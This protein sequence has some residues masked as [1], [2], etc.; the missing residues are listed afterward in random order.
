MK[1]TNYSISSDRHCESPDETFFKGQCL[2][3]STTSRSEHCPENMGLYDNENNEGICDCLELTGEQA[4][5]QL[6]P[7]YSDETGVC[8][9]Q[10]TQVWKF[11]GNFRVYNYSVYLTIKG[12]CE[13]GQW[14]VL[15]NTSQCE[16]VPEGCPTDGLHVSW[17]SDPSMA[18][19]CW[20]IWTQGPCEKG[21][22]LHLAQD[23]E[24][25][26]VYCSYQLAEYSSSN[27]QSY[28]PPC[29][30]G[31]YRNLYGRCTKPGV[32]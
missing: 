24:E 9:R 11:K 6:R 22:L 16:P 3:V 27:S 10:N 20:K 25:I 17:S 26:L 21:Q 1:I 32:G 31:T 4:K 28:Y 30:A 18:K 7:I 12:P 13:N 8:H 19:Q 23:S 14:F 2:L 5:S 15:K 29:P